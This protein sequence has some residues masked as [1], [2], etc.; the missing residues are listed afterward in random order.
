MHIMCR[1]QIMKT[2]ACIYC[3]AL[4]KTCMWLT[5]SAACQSTAACTGKWHLICTPGNCFLVSVV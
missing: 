3:A 4:Q 2:A 5:A 1:M